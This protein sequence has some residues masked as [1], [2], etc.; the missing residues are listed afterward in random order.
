MP[1]GARPKSRLLEIGAAVTLLLA[2]GLALWGGLSLRDRRKL[3]T[4]ELAK[5]LSSEEPTAAQARELLR[6]GADIRVR[7]QKGR[8][9]LHLAVQLGDEDLLDRGLAAGLPA[10]TPGAGFTPLL[11]ASIAGYAPMIRKLAAAGAKVDCA[12]SNG[13][14]ALGFAARLGH[15]EAV[16][17]LLECGARVEGP[18]GIR[19]DVTPFAD[20]VALGNPETVRLLLQ[21]G[22]NP[23][24]R[25]RSGRSARDYLNERLV[26]Q[27]E[28]ARLLPHA[29]QVTYFQG[30][31]RRQE[32]EQIRQIRQ[33]LTRTRS[34]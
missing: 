21:A 23:A 15:T 30:G 29:E 2:L 12:T 7:G 27:D 9:L 32:Q 33:I 18:T 10:D 22:A 31:G 13:P 17:A 28:Q 26:Y 19:Y 5:L 3:A 11:W 24:L 25:D 4:A 16:R 20:A 14:S 6:A 1:S 34:E 8:H